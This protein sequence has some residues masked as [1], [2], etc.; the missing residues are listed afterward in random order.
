MY[1]VPDSALEA[2][3][4]YETRHYNGDY[5]RCSVWLR[6]ILWYEQIH[7]ESDNLSSSRRRRQMEKIMHQVVDHN[8][9]G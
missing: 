7:K 3:G 9:S 4:Y 5:E 1:L 6:D 2:A 8:V